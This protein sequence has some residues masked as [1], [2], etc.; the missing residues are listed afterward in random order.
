MQIGIELTDATC[1]H[2]HAAAL[3]L[4]NNS[5]TGTIPTGVGEMDLG[6]SIQDTRLFAFFPLPR[7]H[8]SLSLLFCGGRSMFGLQQEMTHG[9]DSDGAWTPDIAS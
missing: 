6:K 9:V 8:C 2:P 3:V 5:L 7:G 1:V 4:R